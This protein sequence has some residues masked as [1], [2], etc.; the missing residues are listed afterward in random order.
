VFV[1]IVAAGRLF[2]AAPQVPDPDRGLA[3][4]DEFPWQIS[5]S[6]GETVLPNYLYAEKSENEQII[7]TALKLRHRTGHGTFIYEIDRVIYPTLGNPN[8]YIKSDPEDSLMVVLRVEKT[9]LEQMGA[10][11][12]PIPG[13]RDQELHFPDPQRAAVF[14]LTQK[15]DRARIE[16]TRRFEGPGW[17]LKASR[18][19]VHGEEDLPEEFRSRATLKIY[20]DQNA[21]AAVPGGF[22]DL[23]VDFVNGAETLAHEF[24]YNAVRVF[25]HSPQDDSYTVLNV[26]DSQV[27]VSSIVQKAFGGTSYAAL[28]G[29][30]LKDFVTFVNTSEDPKI[31]NAA[32]I[33]FNGDLH[34]GGSPITLKAEDV[35][36]TYLEESR[37]IVLALRELE[38][39]IFLVPGNH[40]GY[41]SFGHVPGLSR[42]LGGQ[43]LA[44]ALE[45][46][47]SPE[48]IQKLGR[49]VEATKKLPGG[50]HVDLF[51]GKYVKRLGLKS[52]RDWK[53]VPEDQRNVVLYDGFYQWQ[54]TYGPLY[55][56][57]F[58]GKNHYINLNSFDLR[59][60][61][62]S[63]WGMYT[64]NYGGGLSFFQL[65]WLRRELIRRELRDRDVVLLAHHDPRGGHNG[66]DY[67]YYFKQVDYEGL[68][69]SIVNYVRGEVLNPKVCELVP[70]WAKSTKRKL[71][72]LHDG[73][74]EWMRADPEFDCDNKQ[75]LTSGPKAGQCN[76]E[77]YK[78]IAGGL[79][80]HPMYTGYY[81][82]H[83]MA[84]NPRVRTVLLG[85]THFNSIEILQPGDSL[86]PDKVVFDF[87]QHKIAA[88]IDQANPVRVTSHTRELEVS[89]GRTPDFTKAPPK[90]PDGK[91]YDL[92]FHGIYKEDG[93][94]AQD[95]TEAGFQFQRRVK[96]RELAI[97]R[98]TSVSD[99]SAQELLLDQTPMYGFS[100]LGV[101]RSPSST[102][103]APQINSITFYQ[104][105]AKAG[106]AKFRIVGEKELDRSTRSSLREQ[107]SNPLWELFKLKGE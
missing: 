96:D 24:H 36:S 100:V 78:P 46:Y 58:F 80:Y 21:M 99:L 8:L 87:E 15:S 38:F 12:T 66:K 81:L 31:R 18:L 97:L 33:T 105:D 89:Q 14:W 20:F 53:E 72:C 7:P 17:L 27:S 50:R 42:L 88:Q 59:Q 73:L 103:V 101:S 93:F 48:Q 56:S 94:F 52:F 106:A 92:R 25:E 22:Y 57:W 16:S 68:M 60:H 49:F 41:V 19:I 83:R 64:V 98:L 77:L 40:D 44:K 95:L 84:T 54:R 47:A 3:S 30:K 82:I 6:Q 104:R 39:P 13:S 62:R 85:H 35:V 65:E 32:F 67:P 86:V 70:D 63:G 74:Q 90:L 9:W 76:Q 69:D 79:K 28:T 107:R 75:L 55:S 34:N 102:S 23:S 26:T 61:R 37:N 10:R 1:A 5:T 4:E 71:S 2:F 29:D 43:K 11:S 45:P 91:S 51:G